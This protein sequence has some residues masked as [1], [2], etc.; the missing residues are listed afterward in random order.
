M[1]G[2]EDYVEMFDIFGKVRFL[3]CFLVILISNI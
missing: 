2:Y 3:D 1:V